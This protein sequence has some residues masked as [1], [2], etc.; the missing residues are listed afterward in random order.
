[1]TLG[2]SSSNVRRDPVLI[3]ALRS[4]HAMLD[5]DRKGRPLLSQV[6]GPRYQRRLARLAFLSPRIQQAIVEGRQPQGLTLEHLVRNPLPIGWEE[7]ERL[8]ARLAAS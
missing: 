3:R 8:I 7:Q 4:A 6:P 5:H 2:Q 1:M